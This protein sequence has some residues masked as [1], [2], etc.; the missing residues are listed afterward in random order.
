M[1]VYFV[2][3]TRSG[4]VKVGFSTNVA[5]R[6][7]GLR[8]SCPFPLR[9]LGS[10]PGGKEREREL[11]AMFSCYFNRLCGEWYEHS[12]EMMASI[13]AQINQQHTVWDLCRL[14][15]KCRFGLRGLRMRYIPNGAEFECGGSAWDRDSRLILLSRPE[16]IRP[17]VVPDWDLVI[18]AS[19]V[20]EVYEPYRDDEIL[21]ASECAPI[22][23][24]PVTCCTP[25][26]DDGDPN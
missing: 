21:A 10:I 23:P 24:W 18:P 4:A 3:D 11:H 6:V 14:R 8:T 7:S 12:D 16:K 17:G 22:D 2:Q 13:S 20:L 5:K 1:P 19:R 25:E 26:P 15:N 9:F